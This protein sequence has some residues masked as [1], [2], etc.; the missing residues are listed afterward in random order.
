[1][2]RYTELRLR[3]TEKIGV[4]VVV[5]F[6]FFSFFFFFFFFLDLINRIRDRSIDIFLQNLRIRH[7]TIVLGFSKTEFELNLVN[8]LI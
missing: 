6:F 5:A 2:R 8:L 1:M 4:V 7:E 3:S